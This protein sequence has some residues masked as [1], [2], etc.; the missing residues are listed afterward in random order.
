M[1]PRDPEELGNAC[2]LKAQGFAAA[3]RWAEALSLYDMAVSLDPENYAAWEG[4][5]AVLQNL[6][7]L[8]EAMVC[9]QK[10][11]DLWPSPVA[12]ALRDS[13]VEKIKGKPPA[14]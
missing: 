13:L 6:G 3:K 12:E 9:V 8:E 11:L 5:A 14:E 2:V 10:A 7:R 1:E 4:K